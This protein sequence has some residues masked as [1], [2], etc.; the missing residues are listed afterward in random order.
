MIRGFE[1]GKMNIMLILNEIYIYH[2]Y[3]LFPFFLVQTS[4]TVFHWIIVQ[5]D[6]NNS[7]SSYE[8]VFLLFFFFFFCKK[9]REGVCIYEFAV[10]K[11]YSYISCIV[12]H[13]TK[14]ITTVDTVTLKS[15][16]NKIVTCINID[17][18]GLFIT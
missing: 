6:K 10:N 13:W 16:T 1:Y 11:T 3:Y 17:I 7:I 15:N 5:Y 2:K 9:F 12:T 18:I 4:K 14:Y 8:P